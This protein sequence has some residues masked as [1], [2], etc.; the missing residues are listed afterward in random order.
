M[1]N[2]RIIAF[3]HQQ[4]DLKDLGNLVISEDSLSPVLLQ[5][6]SLLSIEEI[7]YVATCNR[8]EFVFKYRGAIDQ[9]FLEQFLRVVGVSLSGEELQGRIEQLQVYEDV[10]AL[11]HLI[12]VSCSLES[13]VV[14]EKEILAQI[15]QSYEKA[16]LAGFTADYLRL[17]MDHVVKAAKAVYTYT[18][19][20]RNPI[21]VVSLAYRK[22]RDVNS[23]TNAR[24][25]IVGAGDTNNTF[26]QYL[27][28]HKYSN[29]AVFNRTLAKAEVL[30]LALNGEAY[31]LEELKSYKKG[32]DILITC[33]S[34]TAPIITPEIYES[35]LN[36]ETDKKVVVDLAV[37]YDIDS[38]IIDSYP[39]HFI[40]VN[41]LQELA[42]KNKQ[43]RYNELV[44]AE[45]IID[46][47]LEEFR[48]VLKQRRI[49]IAMRQVPEQ[50]KEIKRTALDCIFVEEVQNL[51]ENSREVLEKVIDYMEK[52][53]ISV[54]MVMAKEILVDNSQ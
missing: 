14:G 9:L 6:K 4:V 45:K 33:T 49:E 12:R 10:H 22:L 41:T 52:K 30:A 44:H 18:D 2:L 28:K 23:F 46:E 43:G 27:Q 35:L 37:P 38:S 8:V 19:I 31:T 39:I 16:R 26:A 54:P 53:Y 21:S 15:R 32:F 34:A 36:G 3:T 47:H 11:K 42:E 51:D 7:F 50:I 13:L 25:L 40:E 29:F 1:K 5:L 48:S 20:S 17:V 24:I